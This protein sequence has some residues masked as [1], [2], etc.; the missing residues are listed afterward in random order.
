MSEAIVQCV[1]LPLG[2]VFLMLICWKVLTRWVG[3]SMDKFWMEE[4]K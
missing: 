3:R 2:I 1:Y 4:E